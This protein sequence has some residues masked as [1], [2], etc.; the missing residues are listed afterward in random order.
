MPIAGTSCREFNSR[1]RAWFAALAQLA[2][3]SV[4]GLFFASS[5][6]HGAPAHMVTMPFA[7]RMPQRQK[8]QTAS[9]SICVTR[10]GISKAQ[11]I[12]VDEVR[13][14]KAQ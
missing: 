9:K 5:Q 3:L 7:L 12:R 14:S 1:L 10:S 13:R 8:V 11:L 6:S 2:P 4:P